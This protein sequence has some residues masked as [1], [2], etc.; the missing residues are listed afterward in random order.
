MRGGWS[1]SAHLQVAARTDAGC[2][3]SNNEDAFV[4]ADLTRSSTHAGARYVGD[5]DVKARGVLLAVSDGIGGEQAGEVA[6][7]LVVD[8]LPRA[9]GAGAGRS[10]DADITGAV[11]AA[12]HRVLDEGV[13]RGFSMGA[14]LTAAWVK[15]RAAYVAEVGDSRAYVIRAG[16]ISQLTKD[17]S[18]VQLLL[19][20]GVLAPD[21]ARDFPMRN[22]I[23]QAM[24]IQ[25]S[26]AVALGRL[27]L[28]QRDCLLLCSDGL[29]D[30]VGEDD[31]RD[32]V[33]WST[34]LAHA[35]ESLVDLANR[36]GGPDN[37]TVVLAGVG[38]DL[39]PPG[40]YDRIEETYQ[41]LRTFDA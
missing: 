23:L 18:Y 40:P 6:S 20:R 30:T 19:D 2:V 11:E 26:V 8:V 21:E 17:Q 37:I 41:I 34:D 7:A 25:P 31:M 4:V 36:R 5:I 16:R 1:M 22:M 10:S 39:P 24:G 3:R 35:T 15:G 28:R 12:H 32:V 27:D 9:L 38:G 29:T 13:Q 14:T 33:L